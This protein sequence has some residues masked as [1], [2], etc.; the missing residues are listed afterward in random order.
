[1]N[2]SSIK[3]TSDNTQDINDSDKSNSINAIKEQ[4]AAI[5]ENSQ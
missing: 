4:V 3:I 5:K 2:Q 1:M